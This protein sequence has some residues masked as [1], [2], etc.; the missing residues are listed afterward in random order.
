MS[1]ETPLDRFKSVLTGASRAIAREPELEVTWTADQPSQAGGHLRVPMPGRSLPRAQAMEARGYADSFALRLRHHDEA[2]HGRHAPAEPMARACYDAVETVRYEALGSRD[3][4]GMRDNLEASL[5]SRIGGDPITRAV[6]PGD[7]PV[8]T[9][10]AL[11][12]RERLTGQPVPDVAA[13]GVAM[14]REW[15]EARAGADFDALAGSVDNQKAFQ[16]LALDMLQHLELTRA[17]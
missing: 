17:E 5:L 12:L 11:M 4:A 6:Q 3:Y 9:A 16:S 8:Q 1:D 15:I 13:P 10:L 14:L 7:V 2:L